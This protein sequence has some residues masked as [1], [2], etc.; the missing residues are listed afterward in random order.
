MQLSEWQSDLQDSILGRRDCMRAPLKG[1]HVPRDVRLD[2]YSQ[3]YLLRL[4]EALRSNYPAIH[5]LLG[6]EDFATLAQDYV[7]AHPSEH[8][9]IRWFGNHLGEYLGTQAPYDEMP[10]FAEL[11]AFEWALRHTIDAADADVLTLD[12]LM[13]IDP[14][15]WGGL[16]FGVHPSL[17]LHAFAWNVP[18]VWQ[19]L[20]TGQAP[21]APSEQAMRW[22]VW[23]QAD[24]S[25]AW[26]SASA[27]EVWAL[28]AVQAGQ[29][30]AELCEGLLVYESELGDVPRAASGFLRG[31]IEQGLISLR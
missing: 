3:A 25:S 1:L 21:P 29:N 20:T 12:G 17:S 7:A 22:L 18:Q 16:R 28:L 9:S 23:R 30:F 27:A 10:I 24:I 31:W 4:A 14:A 19:A 13:A 11:A 6:D 15:G 2:V 5:L 8:A 26:R